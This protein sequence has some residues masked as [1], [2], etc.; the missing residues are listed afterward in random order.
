MHVFVIILVISSNQ[1][2]LSVT[3]EDREKYE[4][5]GIYIEFKVDITL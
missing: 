1:R 2:N 3:E 4:A 5:W